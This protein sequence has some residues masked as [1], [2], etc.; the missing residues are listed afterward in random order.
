MIRPSIM[1]IRLAIA[2]GVTGRGLDSA[3]NADPF[4]PFSIVLFKSLKLIQSSKICRNLFK[5]HK[6]AK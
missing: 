4:F 2:L 3:R 6:N 1:V 5:H